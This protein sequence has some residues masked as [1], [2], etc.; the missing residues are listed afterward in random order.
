MVYRFI[1]LSDE[2]EDFRRDIL[3][4]SEDTFFNLHNAILDSVGYTKD[5]ISSFFICDDDWS[6]GQEITLIEMDTSSEEDNFVMDSTP[7]SELLEDERQKL[8]YVFEYLTERSFFMELREIIPGQ[9]LDKPKCSKSIGEAPAQTTKFEEILDTSSAKS[10]AT[11][12][13]FD[14]GDIDLDEY[15]D[16]ALGDLSEGN[17]FDDY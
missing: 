10:T 8:I 11:D 17:P 16:E 5:Q 9:S 3:I 4:D 12:D 15:D 2:V 7:L 6:K 14:D 13:F 1:V